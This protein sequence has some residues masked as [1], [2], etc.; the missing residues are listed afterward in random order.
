MLCFDSFVGYSSRGGLQQQCKLCCC[1]RDSL[2]G[3]TTHK[4][5]VSVHSLFIALLVET[6]IEQE[7]C[8]GKGGRK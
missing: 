8:S 1:A 6:D 3:S 7:C 4:G 2:N 5:T